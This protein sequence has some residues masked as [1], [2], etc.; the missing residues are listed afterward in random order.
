MKGAKLNVRI[1]SIVALLL[2]TLMAVLNLYPS[3]SQTAGTIHDPL[4]YATL[5]SIFGIF[6]IS[7][8]TLWQ[9]EVEITKILWIR[10]GLGQAFRLIAYLFAGVIIFSVNNEYWLVEYLHLIFTGSAILFGYIAMITY[11]KF[12]R[13]KLLALVGSLFGVTGFLLGFVFD[14]Y[15]VAWAEVIAATPLAIWVNYLWKNN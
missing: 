8:L 15:S 11:P 13:E 5:V 9:S 12:K 10:L 3:W 14:T 1:L 2:G 7:S 4:L 6:M